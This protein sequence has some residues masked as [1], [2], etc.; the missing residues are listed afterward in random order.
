M[1]EI[2]YSD[3]KPIEAQIAAELT[4]APDVSSMS[5]V[6]PS[7]YGEW[8]FRYHL[9]PERG[10]L[11]RPFNFA[12]LDVVEFGAGL[13]AVSRGVAER[14][15][16]LF[17]IEGTQSRFEGAMARLRGL[18][19]KGTVANFADVT[20]HQLYDVA[21]SIGVLEYAEKYLTP[22]SDFKGDAFAWGLS[23]MSRWLKPN[24]VLIIAIENQMGLKYWAGAGEDHTG[25]RFDGISGYPAG[26]SPRTFSRKV[27]N[28]MLKTSGF[29]KVDEYF[30]FPDYKMPHTLVREEMAEK[31]PETAATLS[32]SRPFE[33]YH[34]EKRSTLCEP[35]ALNQLASAGLFADFANSFLFVASLEKS[36]PTRDHLLKGHESVLAWH[37]NVLRNRP[38]ETQFLLT[39]K[40]TGEVR[41][42]EM[43]IAQERPHYHKVRWTPLDEPLSA[44]G[45]LR[46]AL[47]SQAFFGEREAFLSLWKEFSKS[48]FKTWDHDGML[49]GH[50][51]DALLTNTTKT[52]N[53]KGKSQFTFFDQE[54]TLLSKMSE[55]W[56]VLRNVLCLATDARTLSLAGFSSLADLYHTFCIASDVAPELEQDIALE[57]ALQVD[58][59]GLEA[60]VI[61]KGLESLIQRAIPMANWREGES[62]SPS[63]LKSARELGM[64]LKQRA[65]R[66]WV[67]RESLV[68]KLTVSLR[69][70]VPGKPRNATTSAETSG[71]ST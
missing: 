9:S 11:L 17:L 27:L 58:V 61:R 12:G 35:L 8:P 15:Q 10:N 30:P 18:D 60:F 20:P 44:V 70:V 7:R 39:G 5:R 1:S 4:H 23:L 62:Q 69:Q 43:A 41:K 56:W 48:V 22:P 47:L 65:E 34:R 66:E 37:Y 29:A 25:F 45:S 67:K 71:T 26:P 64:A 57:T 46:F 3:G 40:H 38:T 59:T 54:W 51:V 21:L 63:I 53:E 55:S 14:C 33:D 42:K 16:S 19:V 2:S 36:S 13:G 50:A 28:R 49:D 32:S 68:E 6:S 24:G 31:F 52:T